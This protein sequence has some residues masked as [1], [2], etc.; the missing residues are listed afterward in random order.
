MYITPLNSNTNIPCSQKSFK[1][2]LIRPSSGSLFDLINHNKKIESVIGWA[3]FHADYKLNREL[4]I[5]LTDVPKG[6]NLTVKANTKILFSDNRKPL[7]FF[8]DE[9]AKRS[10]IFKKFCEIIGLKM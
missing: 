9:N 1:A 5:F 4:E 2:R 6:E 8:F 7:Y 3:G 10:D